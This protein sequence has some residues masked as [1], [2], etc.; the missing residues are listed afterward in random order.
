MLIGLGK[1]QTPIDFGFTRS[2]V[3]W[4]TFIK[5]KVSAHYLGNYLSQNFHI[6]CML[7]SLGEDMTCIDIWFTRSKVKVTC[8]AFV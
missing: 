6:F 2:K 7:I 4:V 8:V 3:T 1:D 5:K